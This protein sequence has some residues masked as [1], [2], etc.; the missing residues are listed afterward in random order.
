VAG[1]FALTTGVGGTAVLLAFTSVLAAAG[2]ADVQTSM[3]PLAMT[4]SVLGT[5]GLAAEAALLRHRHRP[6]DDELARTAQL[7][8]GPL[9]RLVGVRSALLV[10]GTVVA[11]WMAV[12]MATSP[13]PSLTAG[14]V[15]GVVALFAVLVAELLERW[16][17]FT[18]SSP[19]RMPGRVP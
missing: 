2:H 9:R 12:G 4:A 15:A 19:T 17:F 18:A 14:A 16:R 8:H 10:L 1:R 6:L 7:L 3:R 5:L 13:T 11:P